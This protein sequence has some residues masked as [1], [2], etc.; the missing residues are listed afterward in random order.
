MKIQSSAPHF[1][2]RDI[3]V[4]VRY[5]VDVLGFDEPDLWGKPPVFA[6]PSRDGFIVMLNQADGIDPAPRRRRGM[7][8]RT[9]LQV[10]WETVSAADFF[11]VEVWGLRGL[12][13][14][15][16]LLVIELSTRRVYFAGATPNG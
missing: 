5:Y 6:M 10:H 2:V 13:T 4:S 1:F 15:Y 9:F 12:V 3:H 7:S 11:T 14:F 16:V 8:W